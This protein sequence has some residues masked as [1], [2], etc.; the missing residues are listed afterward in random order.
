MIV[1]QN[2]LAIG[3]SSFVFVH[4][5]VVAVNATMS[6][7]FSSCSL[8]YLSVRSWYG[9]VSQMS[10]MVMSLYPF[11]LSIALSDIIPMEGMPEPSGCTN[12]ILMLSPILEIDISFVMFGSWNLCGIK[13]FQVIPYSCP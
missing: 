5:G 10:Q 11:F 12:I 3:I 8:K 4:I 2:G 1:L 13:I 7:F 6:G 9:I